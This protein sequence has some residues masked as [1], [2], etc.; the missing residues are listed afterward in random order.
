MVDAG[1][2]VLTAFI[3]P[4]RAERQMAR[5]LVQPGEFIEVFVDTPLQLAEERDTKG[6]Y[7]QGPPWRA[8][9][10]HRHRLALRT[11]GESGAVPADGRDQPR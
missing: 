6:L 2:I 4:F 7:K 5:S 10:L 3:S 9:E 1:L 11:S 8:Q